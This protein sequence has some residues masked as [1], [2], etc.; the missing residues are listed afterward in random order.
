MGAYS[1]LYVIWV[2]EGRNPRICIAA[3]RD[4]VPVRG[5]P[6]PITWTISPAWRSI[7]ARGFWSSVLSFSCEIKWG[8]RKTKG[9]FITTDLNTPSQ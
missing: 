8:R 3:A 2:K 4:E 9:C 7:L 5:G 6:A 1:G